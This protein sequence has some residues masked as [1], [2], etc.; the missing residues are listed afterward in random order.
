MYVIEVGKYGVPSHGR[1]GAMCTLCMD[2]LRYYMMG[3]VSLKG[4]RKKV[5][6]VVDDP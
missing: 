5:G 6:Q 1:V 3:V 4:S 2:V